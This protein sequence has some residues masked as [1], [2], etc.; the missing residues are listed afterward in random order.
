VLF[1][2]GTEAERIH[3]TDNL[4]EVLPVFEFML[5]VAEDFADPVFDAVGRRALSLKL[6]RAGEELLIHEIA[7][8]IAEHGLL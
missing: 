6:W 8:V 7:V 5:Y 1:A 3:V 2:S 4:A